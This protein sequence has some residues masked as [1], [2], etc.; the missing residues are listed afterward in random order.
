M[1]N[2]RFADDTTLTQK[3]FVAVYFWQVRNEV[4]GSEWEKVCAAMNVSLDMRSA[5]LVGVL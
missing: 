2:V 4:L 5:A 1:A 3:Y